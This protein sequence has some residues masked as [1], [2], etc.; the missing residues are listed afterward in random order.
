MTWLSRLRRRDAR[1]A[2][3]ALLLAAPTAARAQDADALAAQ[4]TRAGLEAFLGAPAAHCVTDAGG[5]E[6]CEWALGNRD[7]A[8]KTLARSIDTDSRINVLCE[9]PPDRA[10][11]AR[12]S[13]SVHARRSDQHDWTIPNLRP[14]KNSGGSVS[15]RRAAR[16][17]LIQ[18]ANAALAQARTLLELSRLVG[19]APDE[20]VTSQPGVRSCLWRA[21]SRTQGHGLLAAT[22]QAPSRKKLRLECRLPA[23][24]GPRETG[25]CQVEIGA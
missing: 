13:C 20:C 18:R 6:L 19:A 2:L 22:I 5:L 9:L 15:E 17:R 10:A 7:A 21:T 25:S 8:W 3:A 14:T 12:G 4:R 11:R 23:D 16:E 1:R 24:G